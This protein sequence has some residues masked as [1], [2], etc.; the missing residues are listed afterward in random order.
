MC[1]GSDGI[2]APQPRTPISATSSQSYLSG[3]QVLLVSL[4]LRL[5]SWLFFLVLH[6]PHPHPHSKEHRARYGVSSFKECESV[7]FRDNRCFR[8][9][10]IGDCDFQH[11]YGGVSFFFFFVPELKRSTSAQILYCPTWCSE[12][13][14]GERELECTHRRRRL[15]AAHLPLT[16]HFRVLFLSVTSRELMNRILLSPFTDRDLELFIHGKRR[17]Q[18]ECV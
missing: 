6:C 1:L 18:S 15:A 4:F 3:I 16:E 2:H 7:V 17:L 10:S 11:G 13:G 8:L 5:P 12:T 14:R 9:N